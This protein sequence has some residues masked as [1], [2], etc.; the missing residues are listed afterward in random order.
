MAIK[1]CMNQTRLILIHW[2]SASAQLASRRPCAV[3]LRSP[4]SPRTRPSAAGQPAPRVWS[5]RPVFAGSGFQTPAARGQAPAQRSAAQRGVRESGP[6]PAWL[7]RRRAD[8]RRRARAVVPRREV[9]HVHPLGTLFRRPEGDRLGSL[10]QEIAAPYG[11]KA[12]PIIVQ[13]WE[14]VAQ[15]LEAYPWDTT[16]LIGPMGLDRGGD[17]SHS[18]E[19]VSI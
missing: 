18:W 10:L 16:Y 11:E 15:S 17:G 14:Y 3:R 12:A 4:A 7:P 13:A 2:V 8:R 6:R 1:G 5:K 9:R 19:P